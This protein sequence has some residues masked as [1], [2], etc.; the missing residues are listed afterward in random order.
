MK[1]PKAALPYWSR[2]LGLV[3]DADKSLLKNSRKECDLMRRRSLNKRQSQTAGVGAAVGALLAARLRRPAALRILL[4]RATA[5]QEA[6]RCRRRPAARRAPRA[7]ADA[8]AVCRSVP[9]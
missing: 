8:A 7:L 3:R 9:L 4:R 2:A 1:R 6:G 5:G